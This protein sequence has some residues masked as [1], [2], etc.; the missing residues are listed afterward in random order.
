M[1]DRL[2]AE[3]RGL[4][5]DVEIQHSSRPVSGD[6]RLV[7]HPGTVTRFAPPPAYRWYC[8]THYDSVAAGP[9][10]A[11]AGSCVAAL[12]E[13]ARALQHG[14]PLQRPVYLLITDGEEAGLKGAIAFVEEHALARRSSRSC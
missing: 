14:G 8:A 12:L 2:V 9:G 7:Q 4:G 3:L 11:D 6:V 10:A 5:M 1:R 13:T